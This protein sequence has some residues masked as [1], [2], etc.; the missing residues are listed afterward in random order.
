[1]QT[2][3]KVKAGGRGMNHN[4]IMAEA[5][6]NTANPNDSMAGM[7]V[8]SRVKAGKLGANHNETTVRPSPSV[9]GIGTR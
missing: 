8:K 3:T 6:Q 7:A 4:E 1:M 5:G 9:A 2:R